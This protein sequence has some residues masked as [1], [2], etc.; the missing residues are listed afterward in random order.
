MLKDCPQHQWIQSRN[1]ETR[2]VLTRA[3]ASA[4]DDR[5]TFSMDGEPKLPSD[6]LQHVM[7]FLNINERFKLLRTNKSWLEHEPIATSIA[8]FC[9]SCS[10][11]LAN[12]QHLCT[13]GENQRPASFWKT[14]IVLSHG[15]MR[16]LRLA[17]C[18]DFTAKALKAIDSTRAFR[19]LR[20]LDLNRCG[21]FG[22][23]E[24]LNGW[25]VCYTSQ[26]LTVSAM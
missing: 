4:S 3:Q 14:V 13:K 16:E 9:E 25:L 6:T 11:C 21:K 20:V 17:N 7:S 23:E 8:S 24:V 10:Q 2:V 26:N 15:A 18:D 22:P 12:A 19:S 5:R 1:H